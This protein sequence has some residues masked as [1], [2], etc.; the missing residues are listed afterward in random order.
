[1]ESVFKIKVGKANFPSVPFGLYFFKFH[2][3]GV[4][5]KDG[6]FARDQ[7]YHKEIF[8][9][10]VALSLQPNFTHWQSKYSINPLPASGGNTQFSMTIGCQGVSKKYLG[11]HD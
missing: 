6:Q 4:T 7:G 5:T 9:L 10:I 8:F 1:M 11:L 2:K 3:T